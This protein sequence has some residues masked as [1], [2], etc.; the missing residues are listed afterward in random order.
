MNA[1][2]DEFL[3]IVDMWKKSSADIVMFSDLLNLRF[4]LT[5]RIQDATKTQVSLAFSNESLLEIDTRQ[6]VFQ[7][8]D[9]SE[10]SPIEAS[11][12][13]RYVVIQYPPDHLI[14]LFQLKRQKSLAVN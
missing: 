11:T 2:R 4:R 14:M 10:I 1:S 6:C 3:E 8:G 13:E 5:G 7:R 9:H 12:Y